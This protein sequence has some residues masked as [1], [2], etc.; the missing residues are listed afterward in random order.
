MPSIAPGSSVGDPVPCKS[1]SLNQ[2]SVS[3]QV[4]LD[5]PAKRI[6]SLAKH[7]RARSRM[8]STSA[9]SRGVK[10]I[11]GRAQGAVG[12]SRNSN[13][14]V[15]PLA[16]SRTHDGCYWPEKTRVLSDFDDRRLAAQSEL[17]EVRGGGRKPLQPSQNRARGNT[18]GDR[19]TRWSL[20]QPPV[21]PPGRLNLESSNLQALA[22]DLIKSRQSRQ[23]R[24]RKRESDA[25]VRRRR[26]SCALNSWCPVD[27]PWSKDLKAAS[28]PSPDGRLSPYTPGGRQDASPRLPGR[29]AWVRTDMPFLFCVYRLLHHPPSDERS[30]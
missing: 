12:Q 6:L 1:V 28:S 22:L 17:W 20:R 14:G 4:T 21:P 2:Q 5:W 23:D 25:A 15:R 3:E 13:L 19:H 24:P 16:A 30:R 8:R 7:W 27:K 10:P 18:V 9:R 11:G 29:S 26:G